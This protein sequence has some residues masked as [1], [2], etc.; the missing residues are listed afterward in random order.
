[1]RT[2]VVLLDYICLGGKPI[3][4]SGLLSSPSRD[5]RELGVK[6]EGRLLQALDSCKRLQ[7]L[8]ST[9]RAGRR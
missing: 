2:L 1:M 7:G 6:M 8:H 5:P 4:A 3:S 9:G